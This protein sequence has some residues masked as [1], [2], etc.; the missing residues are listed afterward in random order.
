MAQM[1]MAVETYLAQ[2]SSIQTHDT[3]DRVG[4]IS[5]PTMVLAGE[6]DI[7]IPVS[8]SKELHGLHPGGDLED[9]PRRARLLLGAPGRVQPGAA[10]VLEQPL[11]ARDGHP[12][13]GGDVQTS[14]EGERRAAEDLAERFLTG[15]ISRRQLFARAGRLSA[16]AVGASALG[17]VLAACGG[18]GAG[19]STTATRR[20]RAEGG[21]RAEGGAHGR[22]RQPRPGRVAD[23]H[24]RA[25]LRQHLQQADRHRPR[26]AVLRRAR[27]EVDA[28]RRHDVDVRPRPERDV[29]QRREVHGRRRQVHV[30]ADPRPEDGERVRAAL[31]VDRRGR[32]RE[33]DPG[34]SST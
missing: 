9:D 24:R 8:L 3:R 7:L 21:R 22:A 16:A 27:D 13:Q 26:P 14:F 31:H 28:D 23:L 1:P 32:G 11:M 29:P 25:G 10:R 2:L 6:E 33:P 34:R 20:H 4:G 15:A 19:G 18:K 12:T 5:V 30:R 17:G